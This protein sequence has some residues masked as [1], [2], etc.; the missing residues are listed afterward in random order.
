MPS[1]ALGSL[2]DSEMAARFLSVRFGV[3]SQTGGGRSFELRPGTA[4]VFV[5]IQKRMREGAKGEGGKIIA[6]TARFGSGSVSD[7]IDRART[8]GYSGSSRWPRTK[9]F[10]NRAPPARDLVRSGAYRRG[11]LGGTGSITRLRRDKVTI[12]VDTFRF[13]Q[14]RVFQK[15]R[16]T[17]VR[18]KKM[19]AK[20][21]SKMGWFLGLTFDVWIS[22]RVLFGR[23]LR[24]APRRVALNRQIAHRSA[25]SFREWLITG[26]AVRT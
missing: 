10:G 2:W 4:P 19:G 9:R 13:P 23:G 16:P 17:R 22:D 8:I 7:Q 21:R 3:G 6:H 1:V 18:A 12:G 5:T 25:V 24:I 15:R 11:W 26:K 14:A 20:G